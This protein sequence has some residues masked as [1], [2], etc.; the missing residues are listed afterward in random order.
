MYAATHAGLYRIHGGRASIVAN[1]YQDTMGF[2]VAGPDHFLAGGHPDFREELPPLLGFLESRDAGRTWVKKSLLGKADFHALR[3]AHG[4]VWGYSSTTSELMVS[5]D[6]K[7]WDTR[8]AIVLRDFV[9]S[10]DS[11]KV[12]IASNGERLQRS[13]DGGRTWERIDSPDGPLLLS[14]TAS[15]ELW[16]LTV[17]GGSY[18]STDGGHAWEKRGKLDSQPEAFIAEGDNLYAATHNAIFLSEDD[19]LTWRVFFSEGDTRDE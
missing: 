15:K 19:G 10:P 5:G 13:E 9:V 4:K 18:R 6:G 3:V 8:S 17:R 11:S 12:V 7:R 16:L 2:T 1:R 14:W